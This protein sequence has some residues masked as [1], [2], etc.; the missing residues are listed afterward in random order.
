M[1]GVGWV[2]RPCTLREA[3]KEYQGQT[4]SATSSTRTRRTREPEAPLHPGR[5][6]VHVDAAAIPG[7]AITRNGLAATASE[8]AS[9]ARIFRPVLV[10]RSQQPALIV[11]IR[12]RTSHVAYTAPASALS[13]G[14][15][16]NNGSAAVEQQAPRPGSHAPSHRI[17]MGG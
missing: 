7:A 5:P 10:A 15:R 2:G 11:A 3:G 6:A 1:R 14:T 17:M 9:E 12:S 8:S 4:T 13:H 16:R